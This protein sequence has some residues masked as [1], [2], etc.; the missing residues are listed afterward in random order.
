[1]AAMNRLLC[2]AMIPMLAWGCQSKDPVRWDV[3]AEQAWP[4]ATEQNPVYLLGPGDQ[5]EIIIHTAPELSR[6]VTVAP[7]GRIRL[8]YAGSVTAISRSIEDVQDSLR[9]ALSTEL[10]NPDL[11]VL[12]TTTA[13]QSIFVGGAVENPGRFEL[14]G[15]INPMQAIIMAGGVKEHSKGHTVILIRKTEDQDVDAAVFRPENGVYDPSLATWATLR[16][17]DVVYVSRAP[18]GDPNQ[19][20]RAYIRDALPVDFFLF[21]GISETDR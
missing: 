5:L 13:P 7:D 20:V 10:R 12:L 16:G 19:F 3:L 1:M 11:D 4:E 8:P 6:T 21:F 18:I 9:A 14:P 15:L 17:F 2:L